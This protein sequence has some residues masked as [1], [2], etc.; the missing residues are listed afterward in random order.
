MTRQLTRRYARPL[1]V[2]AL[3]IAATSGA[4]FAPRR[5]A[6]VDSTA[7]APADR[8]FAVTG[9]GQTIDLTRAVVV[10]PADFSGPERKAVEMLIEEIERRTQLRLERKA[11]AAGGATITVSRASD[12][13]LPRE[14]YRIE[15]R[16]SGVSV[17]GHD[18]RG[19]LFGVGHL[20]RTLRMTKRQI[21]LAAPLN[22]TTAPKYAMRGHQ[23]GYRPKP[24]SYD[25]WTLQMWE[26]YIRDLAV[27]GANAIELIPPRSDDDADSPH[28][29]RPQME[30]MVGMSRL[31]DEY[32]L[33][34][35]IWYPA[36]DKDYSDPK[37]V[38]FALNEWGEVFK[39]LPRVDAVLVP[40]GDPGDTPP[41]LLLPLLEKQAANLRRYHPKAGMWVAPQSFTEEWMGDFL[42]IVKR[43]PQWLTGVVYGP[44]TRV[45]L[46]RLRE[47][48]PAKYP[49]R[50]YPDITHSRHCQFP[51]PNWDT[52][53]ALTENR[54]IINPRPTQMASIFRLLQP[55]TVG[56][57]TY[58][59]GCNDDV[60]KF[61]WGALGWNPDA[62]VTDILRDYSRYFIG[63]HYEDTFAQGLLALE[64]NWVGPAMTNAG[65]E[66][67]LA[68]FQA[69]ERAASPQDLLNWRF[70]QALYR[71]YYD[72]YVRRRLVYETAL[73]EQATDRL[74]AAQLTGALVAMDE[75]EKVLDRAVTE[76]VAPDLRARTSEL[77]E[78]LYQSIRMQLSVG[79]YQALSTGRGA[80]LDTID[81]PLNSRLWLK[82]QFKALR[83][84]VEEAERL[85]RLDEIVNWKNPGPGGFYDDLGKAGAQPH[86]V[87]GP[88][89]ETDPQ[90]LASSHV[91]TANHSDG[92][93]NPVGGDFALVGMGLQPAGPFSWWDLA[94]TYYEQPL[95]MRYTNLD[96]AAEYRVRVVYAGGAMR[97]QIRLVADGRFEVHPLI[98]K[99]FKP[100]EFD[101]PRAATADGELTLEWT[102]GPGSRGA[103]RGTQVA[104]IW[105]I[106][107]QTATNKE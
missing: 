41:K 77:A 96:K 86:L 94:E 36:L 69:L 55:H 88:G 43:E 2:T 50:H 79:K 91:T 17:I 3:L 68:Q 12:S 101:V 89:F 84:P 18:A 106:R 30:M 92:S 21:T 103:G 67:T 102:Q 5:L 87:R 70:Q 72:A 19:V 9:V 10:A 45:S 90:F 6:D 53:F 78:A 59:E 51:V 99:E 61:V 22:V 64:Q 83:A 26:Q 100:V 37:T 58:S 33:D 104:E 24:N 34:V 32:G 74:R 71:A 39:K 14:G 57:I 27:F 23:L 25:G 16:G 63:A 4:A 65:I 48:I 80:N 93:R 29:P 54:E 76:R 20:L 49:L 15:T 1:L 97:A 40:G 28:F 107:K 8:R 66:T 60:N 85:K 62:D 44:Q 13:S 31:C 47:L 52:A 73:E 105:L 7:G 11:S 42:A 46:P 35:W 95:V 75:A 82:E 81:F 38:E 56:S 98:Q